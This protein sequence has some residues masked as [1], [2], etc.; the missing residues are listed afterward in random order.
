[1]M[2]W[3]GS[4]VSWECCNTE[5]AASAFTQRPVCSAKVAG[6]G[7]PGLSRSDVDAYFQESDRRCCVRVGLQRFGGRGRTGPALRSSLLE[8][9]PGVCSR[10]GM[11]WN[12]STN[13]IDASWSAAARC[14]PSH[15]RLMTGPVHDGALLFVRRVG[16]SRRILPGGV[17]HGRQACRRQHRHA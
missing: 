2:S 15:D 8:G 12:A 11:P 13:T 16:H 9:L 5:S 4:C 10:W 7:S 3:P 6:L 1:V 17:E 14:K